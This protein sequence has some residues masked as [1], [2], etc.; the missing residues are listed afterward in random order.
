MWAERQ[1]TDILIAV[2]RSLP[3]REVIQYQSL[4]VLPESLR[5]RKTL[6]T[7]THISRAVSVEKLVLTP[8]EYAD[9]GRGTP[10]SE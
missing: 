9:T 5:L 3:E 10:P 8:G 4:F 7:V 2:F 1:P 6:N